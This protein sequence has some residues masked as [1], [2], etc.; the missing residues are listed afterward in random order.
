VP[1]LPDEGESIHIPPMYTKPR[2]I[3][4][5]YRAISGLL[6][7]LIVFALLC[8]GASYYA[9]ASGK[10]SFIHQII[11]DAR[12]Q[13][14]KPSP[15]PSFQ[16]AR[17]QPDYGPAIS[18][19]NSATTASRIDPQTDVA[20]DQAYIFQPNETIFVTYSVHPK[21]PGMVTF[22]WYTNNQPFQVSQKGPIQGEKNG[23]A[24]M[25]F[26]T[27]LQGKVELYWND[28]LAWRLYFVVQ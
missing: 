14:L 22:K 6:S 18:I 17:T 12:P 2:A 8:T 15:T 1:A 4:P 7:V 9:K 21:T 5:P 28:Q 10:L 23:V 26:S 16:P 27:P 11:G 20:L 25:Q 19:I 24:E 3:I 13:N